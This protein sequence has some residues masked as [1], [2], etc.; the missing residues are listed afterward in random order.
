[1][2]AENKQNGILL[3][4][5]KRRRFDTVMEGVRGIR[6]KPWIRHWSNYLNGGVA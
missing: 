4:Q 1:M 3:T 2:Y 5:Y 6:L